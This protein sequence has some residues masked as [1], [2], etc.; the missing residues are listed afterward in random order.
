M[1]GTRTLTLTQKAK[2]TQLILNRDFPEGQPFCFYCG[3]EFIERDKDYCR[4]WDHLN[5]NAGDNRPENLVWAHAKCNELKKRNLEWQVRATEKLKKNVR[6]ALESLGGGGDEKAKTAHTQAQPNEQ[7]DA[8][9]DAITVCEKYLTE[10]LFPKS[11]GKKPPEAELDWNDTEDALGYI[12][13]RKFGHGSQN[14]I[15][16]YLKILTSGPAPFDRASKD[17]RTYIM[18]RTGQ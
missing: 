13:Y 4:E 17:G 8:N 7:I 2:W 3:Q 16:R 1:M 12:C 10:R 6:Q 9:A 14:T 15:R 11:T 18:R 5:N